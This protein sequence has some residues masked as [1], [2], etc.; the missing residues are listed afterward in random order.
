MDDKKQGMLEKN[1]PYI[2]YE[3]AET[4][5]ERRHKLLVIA[6]I[7]AIILMFA[8]NA[9]WLWAWCQY[10]YES[11]ETIEAVQDGNGVNLLGG[12]NITYGS[13]SKDY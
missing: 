11:T 2:V 7:I 12:G 9:A 13:T 8:S 5:A 3:A 10:D 6:L 1:V 4:R